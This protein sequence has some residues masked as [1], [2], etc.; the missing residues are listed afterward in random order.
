MLNRNL[1]SLIKIKEKIAQLFGDGAVLDKMAN[2]IVHLLAKFDLIDERDV[3]DYE[4]EDLTLRQFRGT[5]VSRTSD[6]YQIAKDK[7]AL[8]S[9]DEIDNLIRL[10]KIEDSYG[11][12]SKEYKEHYRLSSIANGTYDGKTELIKNISIIEDKIAI[13]IGNAMK[14]IT[15][16]MDSTKVGTTF[17]KAGN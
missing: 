7:M 1:K 16:Q 5:S 8:L 6:E 10:N 15:I 17:K 3:R 2:G 12:D 9:N 4:I 13:A 11:K 14:N